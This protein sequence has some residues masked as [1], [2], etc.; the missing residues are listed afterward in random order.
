MMRFGMPVITTAVDG[1]DEMFR[2]GVDSLKVKAP[3]ST[4]FGLSV[5]TDAMAEY[6]IRLL[7]RPEERGRLG[8]N[9]YERYR[10]QFTLQRMIRETMAVYDEVWNE[11]EQ[12][13]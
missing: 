12:S 8:R 4:A 3:F 7:E 10:E 1:L 2:D 9:A 13:K 11:N 6:M 5:D